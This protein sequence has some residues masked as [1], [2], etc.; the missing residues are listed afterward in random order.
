M[1]SS[2]PESVIHTFDAC[3]HFWVPLNQAHKEFCQRNLS[4]FEA[5]RMSDSESDVDAF[6]QARK[7]FCRRICLILSLI[8]TV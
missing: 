5:D 3:V 7:E 2:D 4:D 1:K 8:E 6:A